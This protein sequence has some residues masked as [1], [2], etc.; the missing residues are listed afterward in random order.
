[1]KSPD[2]IL[3]VNFGGQYCH[4]LARRVRENN[5]YSEI[6]GTDN[7]LQKFP[8]NVKGIILSGGPSSVYEKNAPSLPVIFFNND[9]P[10]L[11][12]CYGH[13]LIAHKFG[14]KIKR[15]T[16]ME[17][18]VTKTS[19]LN[20]GV[21]LK[22]VGKSIK[23]WMS[24]SDTIS[25][26]PSGFT[27]LAKTQNCPVAAFKHKTKRLYGLQWH[28][29]VIHTQYG[30]KMLANFIF[31]VC[32]A[33]PN[34][35]LE[36]FIS[37][38][39]SDIKTQVGNRKAILAISGG[40]DSSV[41][42]A[43]GSKALG[44]RLTT[45]F[46][47]HGFMR[48]GEP[49][50]VESLVKKL[51]VTFIKVDARKQF[52]DAIKG[53]TDPESKRK[54]IGEQFIRVFEKIA[55]KVDADCLFQGTIYPDRIESGSSQHSSRIK[56]HHNVG[57]LPLNI[58]FKKL[59]EPLRELYKDEVRAV[60]KTLKLPDSL[61]NRQP[62]PGPGLAVRIIG[63]TTEEK[64]ELL[65]AADAIIRKELEKGKL[66]LWQYFGVLTNTLTTGVKGDSR[67]YGYTIAIRAVE[68]REA[69]TARFAPVPYNI[70]E[71]I[72][73]RITNE[74]PETN[75]VVYDITHKPPATIEWE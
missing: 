44:D 12:L 58:K 41:V 47:D 36:D 18:G 45:V 72:S 57:G 69:M 75:R 53:V 43:L 52:L 8:D 10:V 2:T 28:P 56:T 3:I 66:N 49:E 33:K 74:L 71:K 23:V 62:F 60:A 6:I 1:M 48:A 27:V 17:F 31:D 21:L 15:G 73:T 35:K 11:G 63:E 55:K 42:G 22:G 37:R 20:P 51:K 16:K 5:V 9:L 59:I 13:H 29:E 26:L 24:H 68:S 4:L 40:I 25:S 64:L 19:I 14:G 46:V 7:I 50:E 39:V 30:D 32:K 67:A 38:T 70:L 61:I 65:R 34:W 54:I